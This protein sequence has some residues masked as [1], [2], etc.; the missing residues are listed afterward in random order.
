MGRLEKYIDRMN[1]A[2]KCVLKDRYIGFY[3]HGSVAEGTFRWNRSDVDVLI[4]MDGHLHGDEKLTL[5]NSLEIIDE[6]G[7]EKSSEISILSKD[8]INVF[9]YPLPFEFHNSRYWYE[10]IKSTGWEKTHP[11]LLRDPDLTS[12]IYNLYHTH[13]VVEGPPVK[14]VFPVITEEDFLKS[15]QYDEHDASLDVVDT[16]MNL[17][18]FDCYLKNRKPVSKLKGLIHA[19]ET[20]EVYDEFLKEIEE[21]YYHNEKYI[22][23]NCR[24]TAKTFRDFMVQKRE[25]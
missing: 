12:H 23:E 22:P 25:R 17:C 5:L 11:E 6:S 7:P 20:Y 21:L 1:T 8:D 13:I 24:N 18:R 14:D 19:R 9:H 16:V 15:I 2:V 10:N 3:I 4:L